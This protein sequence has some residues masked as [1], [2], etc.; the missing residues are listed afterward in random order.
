MVRTKKETNEIRKIN[1]KEE[2]KA[3]R[4]KNKNEK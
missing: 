3:K 2:R 1:L 4:N